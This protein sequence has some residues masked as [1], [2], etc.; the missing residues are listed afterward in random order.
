MLLDDRVRAR[1]VDECQAAKQV[2]GVVA[3]GHEVAPSVVLLGV[4]VAEDRDLV[5]RRNRPLFHQHGPEER[6]EHARLARVELANDDDQEPLAQTCRQI[7]QA[8]ER[9]LVRSGLHHQ[10]VQL[11]EQ[12]PLALQQRLSGLVYERAVGAK[13]PSA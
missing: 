7:V 11:G 1:R 9:V 10:G 3:L 13:W 6:V 2:G 5:G 8:A 4:A 12:R